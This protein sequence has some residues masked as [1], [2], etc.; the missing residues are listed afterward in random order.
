V[1]GKPKFDQ[2]ETEA[3]AQKMYELTKLQK[4]GK[5]KAKRDKDVL[6][7]AIG[8]KE[9]GGH[10]RGVFSKLTIKDGFQEDQVSYR[11]HNRYKEEMKE[12]AEKALEAKF[13]EFFL[14]HMAEQQQSK[15]LWIN[16]SQEGGETTDGNDAPPV[17]AQANTACAQS[18]VISTT[19]QP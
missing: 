18:S 15:L 6:S 12:A 5:F 17:L 10:V 7:T 9:H 11:R 3:V 4:Q 1:D 19:T 16:S 2:P 8:S 14:A 13:K